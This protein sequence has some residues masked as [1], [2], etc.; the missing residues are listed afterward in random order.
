M[1]RISKMRIPPNGYLNKSIRY[2]K[3]INLITKSQIIKVTKQNNSCMQDQQLQHFFRNHPL[4]HIKKKRSV[5]DYSTIIQCFSIANK[6]ILIC[7]KKNTCCQKNT[8]VYLQL[9]FTVLINTPIILNTLISYEH[10][11]PR[12]NNFYLTVSLGNDQAFIKQSLS[13]HRKLFRT[14]SQQFSYFRNVCFSAF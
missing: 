5:Q 1:T 2:L 7:L 11:I 9:F 13:V 3:L 8:I 6:A 14:H 4:S 12:Q 10:I